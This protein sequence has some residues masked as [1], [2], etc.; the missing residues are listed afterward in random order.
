MSRGQD[1]CFIFLLAL[2]IVLICLCR[3]CDHV[4]FRL[5]LELVNAR[6]LRQICHACGLDCSQ[7][8]HSDISL[9]YGPLMGHASMSP[10]W[11]FQNTIGPKTDPIDWGPYFEDFQQGP[12][13][14]GNPHIQ[15]RYPV[16]GPRKMGVSTELRDCEK[17]A[18]S[19]PNR[20]WPVPESRPGAGYT[21]A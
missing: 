10:V 17:E 12:F 7:S 14:F 15:R 18:P 2:F 5:G 13:F 4:D 20:P 16:C 3:Y 11:E 8:S 21:S 9:H 6:E 19:P 1:S